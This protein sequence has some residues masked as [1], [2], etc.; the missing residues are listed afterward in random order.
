[1]LRAFI[2][3]GWWALIKGASTVGWADQTLTQAAVLNPQPFLTEVLGMIAPSGKEARG[4][5]R[6]G[7]PDCKPKNYNH[8]PT[9]WRWCW[10]PA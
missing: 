1:M 10:P 3:F 4:E 6:H 5:Q 7:P 8:E 9:K 2:W